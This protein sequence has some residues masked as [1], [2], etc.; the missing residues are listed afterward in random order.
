M[1][2]AGTLSKAKQKHKRLN[3]A[4]DVVTLLF[5]AGSFDMILGFEFVN[6]EEKTQQS[7]QYLCTRYHMGYFEVCYPGS[8]WVLLTNAVVKKLR[9]N[10]AVNVS[11]YTSLVCNTAVHVSQ[12][13]ES[14]AALCGDG[15]FELT[16]LNQANMSTVSIKNA[17]V[18]ERAKAHIRGWNPQQF[19]SVEEL[20]AVYCQIAIANKEELQR[21]IGFQDDYLTKLRSAISE[22]ANAKMKTVR[23]KSDEYRIFANINTVSM[24]TALLAVGQKLY[25]KNVNKKRKQLVRTKSEVTTVVTPMDTPDPI[26]LDAETPVDQ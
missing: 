5:I 2:N 24:T 13:I 1:A 20:H 8:Y 19:R 23:D 7:M 16:D 21:L 10:N 11:F 15:S 18:L 14:K 25:I 12:S 26:D 6:L 3:S 4:L 22:H 9:L 17:D